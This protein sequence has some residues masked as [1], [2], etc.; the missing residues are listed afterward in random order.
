MLIGDKLHEIRKAKKITLTELSEKSGVQLAT[1]SRIENKKMTGT[2]ESHLA[3]AKALRIEL[4]ELYNSMVREQKRVE[5]SGNSRNSEI[6]TPNEKS[7][8]E[9]LTKNVLSKQMMPSLIRIEDGGATQQEENSTNS[10]KFIFI[11]EGTVEAIIDNK[12][13]KLEKNNTLY[14]DSS[15]P[16][17]FKNT[18]RGVVKMLCVATPVAL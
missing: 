10:E 14:F 16:H 5:V 11:L 2:L 4:V 8:F 17:K 9:I 18:G 7:S 12:P 1:L 3:I 6:F 15:L 13:F